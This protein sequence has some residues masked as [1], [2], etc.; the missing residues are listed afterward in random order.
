[1]T[2]STATNDSSHSPVESD[3]PRPEPV[4]VEHVESKDN[5]QELSE[6]LQL[7]QP[8]IPFVKD[9]VSATSQAT[10]QQTE[11]IATTQRR[12][13]YCVT[14]LAAAVIAVSII[15]L[16]VQQVELTEKIMMGLLGFLGGFGSAKAIGARKP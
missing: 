14:F 4:K 16:F 11:I 1:M 9:I 13:V 5:N 12:I 3:V 2:Q 6:L 8:I 15:A 7:V 10:T